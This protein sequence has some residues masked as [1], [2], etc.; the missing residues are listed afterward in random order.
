[1]GYLKLT[2][3]GEVRNLSEIPRGFRQLCTI[4]E[5]AFQVRDFSFKYID[6]EGDEITVENET[7]YDEVLRQVRL[8]PSGSLN[9]IVSDRSFGAGIQPSDSL[10]GFDHIANLPLIESQLSSS[11]IEAE[12]PNSDLRFR[13]PSVEHP[14]CQ[15]DSSK[16][17]IPQV[18]FIDSH[19]L[20]AS[21]KEI[22][23]VELAQIR[24]AASNFKG[25]TFDK[26]CSVCMTSPVQGVLFNCLICKHFFM[27]LTC[28]ELC[29][30]PHPMLKIR[31]QAQ[32]QTL[33]KRLNESEVVPS[34]SLPRRNSNPPPEQPK[35][36]PPKSVE[37][38]KSNIEKVIG[39][40]NDMGFF[41]REEIL[42]ALRVNKYDIGMSVN[43]LLAKT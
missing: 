35:P 6:E 22:F 9:L 32:F 5:T 15:A 3:K 21:V 24:G 17:A 36:V 28:E 26:A 27:C 37:S 8:M 38:T 19:D 31:K 33:I 41:N 42:D 25:V 34:P 4:T 12:R 20:R 40:F 43:Y 11:V 18:Q 23:K 10:K 2:F 39:T 14:N 29:Q 13:R 30:H 1:M 7:E 16:F